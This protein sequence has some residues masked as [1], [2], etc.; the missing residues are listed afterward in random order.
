MQCCMVSMQDTQMSFGWSTVKIDMRAL[1]QFQPH[2]PYSLPAF[3][4]TLQLHR[5]LEKAQ[6]FSSY[7]SSLCSFNFLGLSH[8]GGRAPSLTLV[9][10][11]GTCYTCDNGGI[12]G[13][14]TLGTLCSTV[15]TGY[16]VDS[17]V[18]GQTNMSNVWYNIN[19]MIKWFHL[20]SNLGNFADKVTLHYLLK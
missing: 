20:T 7:S 16:H 6:W 10:N 9:I 2:M 8:K 1:C 4:A 17:P 15:N 12:W 18:S 3:A 5:D 14:C 13:P 19:P 11:I